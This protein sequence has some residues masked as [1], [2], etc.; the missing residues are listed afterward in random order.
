M[1]PMKNLLTQWG[2][3]EKNQI[4]DQFMKN[5]STDEKDKKGNR[6]IIT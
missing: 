2:T 4:R 3:E 6:K 1:S 5:L